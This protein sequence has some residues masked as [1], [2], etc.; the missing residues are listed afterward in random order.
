MSRNDGVGVGA[1]VFLIVI[2][3]GLW[4]LVV[5]PLIYISTGRDITCTVTDKDRGNNE[6]GYRVYTK[7]CGVLS[8]E[9]SLLQGKWNSADVQAQLEEG[10]VYRIHTN[11]IRI[12]LFSDFPNIGSVQEVK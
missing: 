9:D 1:F 5:N 12:P 10:H 11:G 3:V 4:T 7:E 6:G 8:N 2:L